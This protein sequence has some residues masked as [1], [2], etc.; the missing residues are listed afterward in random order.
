MID[1]R[2]DQHAGHHVGVDD[3][4]ATLIAVEKH[5]GCHGRREDG[6]RRDGVRRLLQRQRRQP[7]G[8]L[9]ERRV[10]PAP[11]SPPERRSDSS[12]IRVHA[13]SRRVSKELG[14]WWRCGEIR[15]GS[16]RP[17]RIADDEAFDLAVQWRC[18]AIVRLGLTD[19][20]LA[21]AASPSPVPSQ[22]LDF[23]IRHIG[24]APDGPV[25]DV[26][27]GL[28]GIA[29]TVRTRFA[30]AGG[31]VRPIM[32]RVRRRLSS[33]SG[34]AGGASPSVC[35]A[36]PGAHRSRC[37]RVRSA[38]GARRNAPVFAEVCRVMIPAGRFAVVDLVSASSDS[39]RIGSR[40]YPPAESIA[41]SIIESGFDLVDEA[42]GLMTLSDWALADEKVAHDVAKE[43]TWRPGVRTLARR[44]PP[45]RA[46][47]ELRP[48]RDGGVRRDTHRSGTGGR[49]PKSAVSNW[50]V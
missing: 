12:V 40:V 5:G 18:E 39:V 13:R 19:G 4:D 16:R 26:G 48:D 46:A 38:V 49:T 47:D 45:P 30:T 25:V 7:D 24:A 8:S 3:I 15:T 28:A 31:G 43:T 11:R 23:A 1:A 22:L 34:R 36:R 6:G 35:N 14:E 50:S 10:G 37:S 42:I 33:V 29:E 9:A 17:Y 41:G 20:R 44:S 27:A 21:T 32:E 2:P